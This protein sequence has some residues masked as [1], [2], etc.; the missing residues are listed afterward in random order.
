[1][2]S[3]PNNTDTRFIFQSTKARINAVM[4][5]TVG[6]LAAAAYKYGED[7][8]AAV[9]IG[10][11]CNSSYLE[12][13]EKITKLDAKAVGYNHKKM[14]TRLLC[15][16]SIFF[17]LLL[18]NGK[19]LERTESWTTSWLHLIAKLMMHPFTRESKCNHMKQELQEPVSRIDKLTGALYLGDLVRRILSQL[20][21][22]QVLFNG[23]PVEKLDIPDHFPAKYISEILRWLFNSF[24]MCSVLVKRVIGASG[25]FVMNWKSLTMEA[26]T[27]RLF[28]LSATLLHRDLPLLLPQVVVYSKTSKSIL[29]AISALLR[30]INRRQIK[31]RWNKWITTKRQFLWSLSAFLFFLLSSLLP[32]TFPDRRRRR[33]D[34]IS[35]NLSWTSRSSTQPIGSLKRWGRSVL[36]NDIIKTFSGS[37]CLPMKVRSEERP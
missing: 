11:G 30:H 31:V 32:S 17:R 35:S 20:V 26:M 19:S 5:D 27:T 10:Y 33:P 8:V 7:C 4:N 37:S 12:D 28:K 36:K 6:Q 24:P 2:V 9:V 1:M 21:V 34:S 18:P 16:F 25:V 23:T 13:T 3:F 15:L 14:V 22:D 29:L